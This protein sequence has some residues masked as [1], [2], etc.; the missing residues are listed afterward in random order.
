MAIFNTV[1][2]GEWA[3]I[4]REYKEVEYIESSWTQKISTW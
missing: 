3:R 2:G 4:P 1:Y